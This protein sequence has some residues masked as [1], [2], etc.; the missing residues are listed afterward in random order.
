VFAVGFR[1]A[2]FSPRQPVFEGSAPQKQARG[3]DPQSRPG[4]LTEH[5]SEQVLGIVSGF[6]VVS[7]IGYDEEETRKGGAVSRLSLNI[8]H[9]FENIK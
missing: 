8:A 5:Q 6:H 3:S 2:V 4:C 1:V 7:P 9:M